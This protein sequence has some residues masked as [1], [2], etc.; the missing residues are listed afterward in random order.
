MDCQMRLK[1]LM[2]KGFHLEIIQFDFLQSA[3]RKCWEIPIDSL[4]P[5]FESEKQ[6]WTP[7]PAQR[8]VF[9]LYSRVLIF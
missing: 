3:A 9:S 7:S 6:T 8:E 2:L 4:S 1:C 5:F